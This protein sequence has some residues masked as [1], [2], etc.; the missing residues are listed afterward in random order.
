MTELVLATSTPHTA[1]SH[2]AL[3]GLAAILDDA[4]HHDVRLS[5]TTGMDPRPCVY[6]DLSTEAIGDV[7]RT[8]AQQ[9][10]HTTSWLHEDFD[11]GGR[12]VALMSPRISKL[13]NNDWERLQKRRHHVLDTLTRQNILLDLRLIAALGEPCYWNPNRKKEIQQ[14]DA[15]SRWD[16][17]PRNRGSELVTNRLRPLADAVSNRTPAD[18]VRGLTGQTSTDT[19]GKNK[20]DSRTATG[21][22]PLGP[23]DDALAWCGL[24]GITQLP[25]T[26]QP[27]ARSTTT[28]HHGPFTSGTMTLPAWTRP[29]P[30]ARLRTL[31]TAPELRT[32]ADDTATDLDRSI[33]RT[34][35]AERH[36]IATVHFPIHRFGTDK[37]PE[38]R[39]QHGTILTTQPPA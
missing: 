7:V 6:S 2:L 32:Y 22:A 3:Y 38:R 14:D 34:R 15:A 30:L 11:I 13:A 26:H 19:V 31:L 8:H 16:M 36:I 9:R 5:W 23:T 17:Q 39:T 27:R 18:I 35:L 1:L 21:L 4:G 10:T 25:L 20:P 37:A 29:W 33:A 12:T 24:W 28:G